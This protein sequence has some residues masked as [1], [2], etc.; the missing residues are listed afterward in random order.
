MNFEGVAASAAYTEFD[1]SCMRRALEIAE[2]G[3]GAVEPNPLVGCVIARDENIL[4]EGRHQKFGQAHAE[5]NALASCD[6]IPRGAT[7]YVTLEPCC[8]HGKTP[9]CTDALLAAGVGRV[10]VAQTDPFPAVSG[11][12][13]QQLRAAGVNVS[14]GLLEDQARRLNAPYL[15]LLSAQR[16]W[17][18]AKWAM[19]LDGRIATYTGDSRWISGEESRHVVHQLRG[20]VDA[21]IVGRGTATADDP[22]LT[23]RPP[24]PRIATRIVLDSKA[25]TSIDSQLV[26]T[27]DQAPVVIVCGPN[28]DDSRCRQLRAAGCEVLQLTG[29]D[30]AT[31]L[32]QLLQELGRRRMTN[33]LVEGGS[34]LLGVLAD[35]QWIDEAW[36]FV[37][38]KLIGGQFAPGPISGQGIAKI[39]A[40]LQLTDMQHQQL[41][42]DIWLRGIV[43]R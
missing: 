17:V 3:R 38:P 2:L 6:Q 28:A 19:S 11:G 8:H 13:L 7:V 30:Q 23:A 12:G 26:R 39:S 10:V 27:V 41:G 36:L 1:R 25:A 24:G 15:K 21:V 31:R 14:V 20:Q 4:G 29:G 40:A 32:L 37:A 43:V 18:I 5:V 34:H 42:P 9:P 22:L 33:V 16:P 35:G